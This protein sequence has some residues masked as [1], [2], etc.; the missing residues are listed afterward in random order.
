MI[1]IQRNSLLGTLFAVLLLVG[2]GCSS[3]HK[4][5]TIAGMSPAQAYARGLDLLERG[6]PDE[7]LE[8]FQSIDLRFAGDDREVL[9]PLIRLSIADATF[10][11]GNYLAYI[12]AR[13]LYLNFI[14]LYSDHDRAPYAQFQAGV[15]SLNQTNAPS[16]DQSQTIAA[17]QDLR[18]IERRYPQSLYSNATRDVIRRA[19]ERLA[20]HELLVGRF[21]LKRKSFVAASKRFRGILENYPRYQNTPEVYYY[22]AQALMMGDNTPEAKQYLERILEDYPDSSVTKATVK[23]LKRPELSVTFDAYGNPTEP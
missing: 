18:E 23:T 19:E 1:E 14:T 21:Y 4:P 2:A 5:P 16:K 6:K 17:F 20:D 12:D 8:T 7:A 3:K 22:L 11:Q 15:C 10:Y 9:E 13:D